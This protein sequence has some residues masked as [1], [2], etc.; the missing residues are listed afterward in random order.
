MIPKPKLTSVINSLNKN[1]KLIKY[2]TKTNKSIFVELLKVRESLV[3]L[4]DTVSN[5]NKRKPIEVTEESV[6]SVDGILL[7]LDSQLPEPVN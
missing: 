3:S 4:K 7:E 5:I 6:V 2:S 1:S